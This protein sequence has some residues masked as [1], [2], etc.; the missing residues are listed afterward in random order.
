MVSNPVENDYQKLISL[1][2]SSKVL[3]SPEGKVHPLI[4]NSSLRLV[5]WLVSSKVYLQKRFQEGLSTLS[6]IP[7]EQVLSKITNRPGEIRL[8]VDIGN[9][10]IPL[11]TI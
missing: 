2:K 8:A 3:L 9:K 4:Q 5:A 10:V 1:T 6:Q 7:E 11:V